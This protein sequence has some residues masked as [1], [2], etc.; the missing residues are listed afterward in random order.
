MNLNLKKILLYSLMSAAIFGIAL[1]N[2]ASAAL[3]TDST[4]YS[5]AWEPMEYSAFMIEL[6]PKANGASLHIYDFGNPDN[7]LPILDDGMFARTNLYFSFVHNLD[8][9]V[10]WYADTVPEGQAL[11]LGS[12]PLFGFYFSQGTSDY[13]TYNIAGGSGAYW[14]AE[15]N[16]G[17]ELIMLD[18]QPAVPIPAAVLLLGSGFVG[19]AVLKRRQK[20]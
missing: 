10:S 4:P 13:M 6:T 18:A 17:M 11:A 8:S 20:R 9:S 3:A 15:M 12:D 19:M 14:L 1:I 7:N 5:G 16:T 2:S